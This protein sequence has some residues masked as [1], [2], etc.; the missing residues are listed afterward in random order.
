MSNEPSNERGTSFKSKRKH[1]GDKTPK[2]KRSRS[3]GDKVR[4]GTVTNVDQLAWKKVSLDNDEFED[5]EEIEGVDVEYV[6][7]DG[8]K[9]IQFKVCMLL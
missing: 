2:S 3:N 4:R 8:N 9:L 7:T 5:F 6:E 1:E